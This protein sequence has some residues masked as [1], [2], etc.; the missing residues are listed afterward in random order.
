MTPQDIQAGRAYTCKFTVKDI[1]LDEFDRPGGMLSLTDLPIKKYGDYTSLGKIVAR[2]LNTRLLEVEENNK[3][4]VVK[5]SDV[6]D[7]EAVA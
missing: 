1:P 4:Y 3:K 2:D 5:F 6:S 7:I